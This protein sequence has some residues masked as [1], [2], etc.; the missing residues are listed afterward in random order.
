MHSC[1]N[2]LVGR[3]A[4]ICVGVATGQAN[5]VALRYSRAIRNNPKT[6]AAVD[7]I[8]FKV[9]MIDSED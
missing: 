1:V 6:P 2:C 7:P 5:A 4:R 9:V 8:G 3:I